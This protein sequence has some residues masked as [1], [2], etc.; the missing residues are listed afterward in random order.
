MGLDGMSTSTVSHS[1][2]ECY[3]REILLNLEEVEKTKLVGSSERFY[4]RVFGWFIIMHIYDAFH[5]PAILSQHSPA[6]GLS[7]ITDELTTLNNH[8]KPL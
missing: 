1:F 6:I 3:S 5:Q 2:D 4:H 7:A 8:H